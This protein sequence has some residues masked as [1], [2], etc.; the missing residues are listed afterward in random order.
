MTKDEMLHYY[1]K[2][3]YEYERIYQKPERQEDLK[4]LQSTIAGSF[5][6]CKLLEIACGTGY[7]THFACKSAK[8]IV[9]TDYNEEVLDIAR[10]KDYGNCPITFLKTD[11]YTLDGV[12]GPFS[13][14]LVGFWWS[15]VPKSKI[16]GFLKVLH[17]R[18]SKGAIV[19]MLDNRYVEGS[20][21]PIS[22]KDNEENT[23]QM[24]KLH[25]GSTHEVLKNFPAPDDFVNWIKPMSEKLQFTELCY[26]WLA[27]YTLKGSSDYK[28]IS[29]YYP[30]ILHFKYLI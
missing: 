28:I 21:T 30:R 13:A 2:R 26:F 24:R 7:W 16:E 8:S 19:I 12:A 29:Y 27:R 6:D 4:Q 14:A 22:R 9:A 17:S 15:H 10:K 5:V 20:S 23:Y 25:D 1:A 11:A 18:L 3:A